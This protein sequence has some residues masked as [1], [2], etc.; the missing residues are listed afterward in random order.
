MLF[1]SS[2]AQKIAEQTGHLHQVHGTLA[3][4][5]I[6][7]ALEKGSHTVYMPTSRAIGAVRGSPGGEYA[8]IYDDAIIR[9][10]RQKKIMTAKL[11]QWINDPS[12]MPT[13][14]TFKRNFDRNK[15]LVDLSCIP[16]DVKNGIINTFETTKPCDRSN[17]LNYFI[18]NK[19]VM[20]MEHISDF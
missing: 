6:Q 18:A 20:M 19:M 16:N 7:D 14:E 1:R 3:K 4:A 11:E 13:D 12:T 17:L 8:T 15:M 5:A 2:D 10:E 9:E